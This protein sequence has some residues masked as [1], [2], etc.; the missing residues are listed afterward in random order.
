MELSRAITA[1][2][3]DYVLKP[4]DREVLSSRLSEGG[5]L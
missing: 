1:G 4:Y 2:A 5:I 3:N